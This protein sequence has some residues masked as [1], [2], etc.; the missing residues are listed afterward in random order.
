MEAY[1]DPDSFFF[2]DTATSEIYAYAKNLDRD[3]TGSVAGLLLYARTKEPVVPD[4]SCE[5]DGTLIAAKTLD[6]SLPFPEIAGQLDR[7]A[8][9]LLDKPAHPWNTAI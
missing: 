7:I 9:P 8:Q 4:D 6:L 1:R 3:R 2:N 5:I